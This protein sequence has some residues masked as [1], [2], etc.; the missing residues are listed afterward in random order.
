MTKVLRGLLKDGKSVV[1]DNTHVTKKQRKLFIDV[2]KEYDVP[3]EC[4]FIDT[5]VQ[6]CKINYY[7][8]EGI[9][10]KSPNFLYILA[11]KLEI[12]TEEEGFSKIT[13]FT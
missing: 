11:S 12:P 8:R 13:I 10:T 1:L 3:I 9:G 6:Q 2:I 7:K 5:S 4:Y